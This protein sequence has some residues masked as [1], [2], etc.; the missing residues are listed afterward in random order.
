M[1]QL[2]K[3]DMEREQPRRRQNQSLVSVSR[4]AP[5]AKQG[6]HAIFQAASRT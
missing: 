1:T 3:T 6:I 5:E 4:P 2:C